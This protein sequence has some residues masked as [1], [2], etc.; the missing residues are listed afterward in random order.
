MGIYPLKIVVSWGLTSKNGDLIGMNRVFCGT[1]H[2]KWSI[3][4]VN[5]HHLSQL[6][7]WN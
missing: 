6:M 7:G 4:V 3:F 1:V 2:G 5:D